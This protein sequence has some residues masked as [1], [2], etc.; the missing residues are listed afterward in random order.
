MQE[1]FL[2]AGLTPICSNITKLAGTLPLKCRT[3]PSIHSDNLLP[4]AF[5]M[6]NSST[7]MGSLLNTPLGSIPSETYLLAFTPISKLLE[8]TRI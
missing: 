3:L 4:Q 8:A 2:S 6:S 7:L 1:V 5:I